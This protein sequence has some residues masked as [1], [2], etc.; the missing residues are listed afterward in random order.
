MN[1]QGGDIL[2]ALIKHFSSALPN[3]IPR[4]LLRSLAI[5]KM[6]VIENTLRSLRAA[7]DAIIVGRLSLDNRMSQTQTGQE[8]LKPRMRQI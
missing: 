6:I 4:L 2:L 3:E 8:V 7:P 5:T 1:M